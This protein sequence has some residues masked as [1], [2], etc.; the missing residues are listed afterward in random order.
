MFF[1]ISSI[2]LAFLEKLKLGVDGLSNL[3]I[4]RTSSG[5]DRTK[6]SLI[7]NE[8]DDSVSEE[9]ASMKLIESGKKGS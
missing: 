7:I 5:A 3:S 1:Y 6:N 4:I 9:E 2:F 8:L